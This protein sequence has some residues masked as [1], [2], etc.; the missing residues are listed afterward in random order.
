M[1]KPKL[2]SSERES[3]P[4]FGV[5]PAPSYR[6]EQNSETSEF[7][8]K[9]FSGS[10]ENTSLTDWIQL[11]Q[12]GRRDAVV[13]VR[14]HDRKVG[15]LWCRDGDII[16]ASCDGLGGA[17]AVYC[18]LSWQGG[19]VVVEF[20]TFERPRQIMIA[21]SAL[22]LEAAYRNDCHVRALGSGPIR[23]PPPIPR[24]SSAAP[25]WIPAS[26]TVSQRRRRRPSGVVLACTAGLSG[27]ALLV[28]FSGTVS[29]WISQESTVPR[30][31]V[32]SAY[33][34]GPAISGEDTNAQRRAIPRRSDVAP[35]N[36]VGT[37]A[38]SEGSRRPPSPKP[39]KTATAAAAAR[40][41]PDQGRPAHAALSG[42]ARSPALA[43][44]DVP[45][46]EERRPRIQIIEDRAPQIE[47]IQ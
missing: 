24:P 5:R 37:V 46:I 15:R 17:D 41:A 43:A 19:K 9:G 6:A 12:M 10:C 18:A 42:H 32:A 33:A 26:G 29:R 1:Q 8:P 25:V 30:S 36:D 13:T 39:A 45:I 21:T 40:A 7:D 22:L 35:A 44:L 28:L 20:R 47:V 2:V 3:A 27:F 4:V 31:S 34:A 14:A 38:T 16:D 23:V 11:V